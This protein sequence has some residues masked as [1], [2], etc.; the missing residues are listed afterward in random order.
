MSMIDC[1][2]V[3]VFERLKLRVLVILLTQLLQDLI[4][5][6]E[7]VCLDLFVN[8]SEAQIEPPQIAMAKSL[9]WGLLWL[10]LGVA[11]VSLCPWPLFEGAHHF[12]SSG[13]IF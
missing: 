5:R 8:L 3:C 12:H 2:F 9:L 13:I 1:F 10:C 4:A 11:L 6:S 7:V